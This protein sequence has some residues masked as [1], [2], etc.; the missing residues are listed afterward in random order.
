MELGQ[1]K[2]EWLVAT[3]ALTKPVDRGQ[4]HLEGKEVVRMSRKSTLPS[5]AT[6][7]SLPTSYQGKDAS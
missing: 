1:Q 5:R 7:Q 4:S 3:L 2:P 6:G